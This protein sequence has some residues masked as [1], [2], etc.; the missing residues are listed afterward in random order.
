M[1]VKDRLQRLTGEEKKPPES[2]ARKE[3]ISRLRKRVEAIL[4]RR[5]AD[6][7]TPLKPKVQPVCLEELVPGEEMATETGTFF[8][9]HQV[10]GGSSRHGSRCIRDLTPLD[11]R[12]VA[13]LANDPVLTDFDLQQGLFLDTETTGLSG[14]TGTVAFLIGLGWFE[15]AAFITKQLFARDYGE[16]KATLAYLQTMAREKRFL[17]TFNGKSFDVNLLATRFIMNRL[18]DPLAALPHVDLIHSSRRIFSHRLA[19]RSLGSLEDSLLGFRREGDIPGFEIPGRYFD[20]LRRRDGRLMA[21]VFEHNRFDILSMAALLS[22]LTD[23]I[24]PDGDKSGHH[25]GDLLAAGRLFLNRGIADDAC[26]L[27]DL[28]NAS[29]HRPSARDACREMSLLHKRGARWP[30]AVDLWEEMIRR[31]PGDIFALIELAKWCEHRSHDLD[32]AIT[33]TRLALSHADGDSEISRD[34]I[35]HRLRRLT[36]RLAGC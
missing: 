14:G 22:H 13:I 3:E 23:V 16:E 25:P 29:G 10:A 32:R 33:L 15:G 7:R 34:D 4:S 18:P 19:D 8:C 11:M 12:L 35:A 17:V 30:Q 1:S 9:S 28:V 36:A 6:R 26:R 20:W 31:D 24:D 5:P 21:D 2:P 27:L